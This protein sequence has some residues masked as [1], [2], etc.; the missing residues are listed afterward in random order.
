[1][2]TGDCERAGTDADVKIQL[3]G[4]KGETEPAI[5]DFSFQDDFERNQVHTFALNL[6]IVGELLCCKLHIDDRG[7]ATDWF[8]DF[9]KVRVG[10]Q[11][12][13]FPCYAWVKDGYTTPNAT[14]S[15]PQNETN[16]CSQEFRSTYLAREK[17][18]GQIKMKHFLE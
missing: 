10:D 3:I 17:N 11:L 16:K 6:E 18:R 2:K 7:F 1:L 12:V 15:L 5:L 9:I 8:V 13:H 14:T 4:L